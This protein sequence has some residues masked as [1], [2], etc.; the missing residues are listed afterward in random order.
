M[1]RNIVNKPHVTPN[2]DNAHTPG[3]PERSD[4]PSDARRPA[5][6]AYAPPGHGAAPA[7]ELADEEPSFDSCFDDLNL[8]LSQSIQKPDPDPNLDSSSAGSTRLARDVA[9]AHL[10]EDRDKPPRTSEIFRSVVSSAACAPPSA[11]GPTSPAQAASKPQGSPQSQPE[12]RS[13]HELTIP[14]VDVDRDRY[15]QELASEEEDGLSEPRVSWSQVL[16]LSYSSAITLAMI[17]M[18]WT[19]RWSS[20]TA[21]PPVSD[22]S[23]SDSS[24]QPVESDPISAPPS[25]PAEN[26]ATLGK[27]IRLGDLEVT[28]QSVI[29]APVELMRSIEPDKRRRE[30]TSLIL[31]LRLTNV[32]KEHTFTPLVQNLV[33]ERGLRSYDPYIET[34]KGTLIRLFPLAID[35]E[36]SIVGQEF[37]PLK[38]GET[39]ETFVAA[40]PG[41]ARDLAAEMTWRVRLRTG[42]YRTDMLGVRFT[43]GEVRFPRT[44]RPGDKKRSHFPL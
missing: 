10:Q 25:I 5:A 12:A 8:I 38:P 41:S 34:S 28:P 3:S 30:E 23:T 32:S 13:A 35:S 39:E 24:S 16:L 36:W 19:G 2:P 44:F 1:T 31:Q 26:L 33:R 21:P 27:T 22:P 18:F 40:E 9:A 42:V 14:G 7:S 43:E 29:A 15:V 6:S 17:W 11:A 37:S 4:D 20:G